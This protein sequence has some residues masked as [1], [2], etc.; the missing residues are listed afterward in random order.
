MRA[1]WSSR[2]NQDNGAPVI[3]ESEQIAIMRVLERAKKTQ[4][5]EEERI[6]LVK[7]YNLTF[8]GQ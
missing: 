4:K 5:M 8:N 1:G 6:R 7:I 3:N 2:A